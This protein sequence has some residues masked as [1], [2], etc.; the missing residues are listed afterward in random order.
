MVVAGLLGGSALAGE[1]Q[2][3]LADASV[4][5]SVT[6]PNSSPSSSETGAEAVSDNLTTSDSTQQANS[7]ATST[8]EVADT[9]VATSS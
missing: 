7:V 4:A 1:D 6:N 9:S 5:T 2:H 8:G 3:V